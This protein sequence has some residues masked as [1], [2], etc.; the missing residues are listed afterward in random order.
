[1]S[2]ANVL[3]NLVVHV[4]LPQSGSTTLQ[5][6]VFNRV[7]FGFALLS[8]YEL[9]NATIRRFI[10]TP[11]PGEFD[12]EASRLF[13][14]E[15][16]DAFGEDNLVP[17][18]SNEGLSGNFLMMGMSPE[19]ELYARRLREAFA[20]CK[21]LIVLREQKSLFRSKYRKYVER[22]EGTSPL[23]DFLRKSPS[24]ARTQTDG[25]HLYL[26]LFMYDNLLTLYAGLFGKQ[27]V[28]ALPLE[29]MEKDP[30]DFIR[31]LNA[32]C[33]TTVPSDFALPRD[34]I[35]GAGS[36]TGFH[37]G[38][39][40]IYSP[41]SVSLFGF[42]NPNVNRGRSW[43]RKRTVVGRLSTSIRNRAASAG[44]WLYFSDSRLEQEKK[45]QARQIDDLVGS[46]FE[47]SNDRLSTLVDW[48]LQRYG[49]ATSP[50]TNS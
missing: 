23:K 3:K 9:R 10:E 39:N 38:Y 11:L 15:R 18:L 28:C 6:H 47:A 30:Q 14:R 48:D 19:T 49:Y 32:F 21:I 31:R 24:G 35:H 37:R 27:N 5:K 46:Y 2:E 1:M 44:R 4:G 36:T 34:N 29:M 43:I 12:A 20:D 17:I 22:Y 33:G 26:K 45:N 16:F 41:N 40:L 42:I 50:M 13:F 8:P 7:D 25:D